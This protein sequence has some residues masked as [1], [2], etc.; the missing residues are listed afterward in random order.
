[1]PTS[2]ERARRVR[3]GKKTS[4]RPVTMLDA[5]GVP[6]SA[7]K[8]VRYFATHPTAHP[9]ARELQRTLG[10]GGASAQR[11]LDHLT[12]IGALKRVVDGRL[13]RYVAQPSSRFWRGIR[14]LI[15]DPSNPAELLRDSLCDVEGV[16]AAFVFGSS[17]KGTARPDSDIDV[18]VV[19]GVAADPK[20]LHRQLGEAAVLLGREVNPT[21]Y[22]LEKLAERL[23]NHA[24]PGSRFVREVLTGPKQWVAGTPDALTPVALA[25]GI[26]VD[27]VRGG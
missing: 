9:Y 23:G 20:A 27:Q 7:E 3:Q 2:Q 15:A 6:T 26:S 14:L 21:R 8:T 1:M 18:F 5:L 12:E 19:E 16:T 25:A 13:V 4:N 10:L 17:A 24:L 11:D 22:T